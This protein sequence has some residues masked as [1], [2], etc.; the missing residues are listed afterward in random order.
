MRSVQTPPTDDNDPD[1]VHADE[2]GAQAAQSDEH[3]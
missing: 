2:D 3:S 1:H